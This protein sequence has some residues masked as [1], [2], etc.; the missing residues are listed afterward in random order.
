VNYFTHKREDVSFAHL[1]LLFVVLVQVEKK[2]FVTAIERAQIV[3]KEKKNDAHTYKRTHSPC[4]NQEET[5][6][7]KQTLDTKQQRKAH[8]A[9]KEQQQEE[10]LL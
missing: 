4:G 7:K 2:K 9:Q 5:K 8:N 10:N 1:V 6:R 3:R